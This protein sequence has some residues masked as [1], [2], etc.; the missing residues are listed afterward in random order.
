MKVGT[1][2]VWSALVV[3][4]FACDALISP[5]GQPATKVIFDSDM[6]TDIDDVGALSCLHALADAGEC[7]ILATVSCTRGN[8][9]VG[10]IQVVNAFYGRPDIPVG[11][12]KEI[13]VLGAAVDA[14]VKVD[15]GAPLGD[16]PYGAHHKYRKLL[17]DYPGLHSYA[18]SDEAPDAN[19]VYRRVLSA[20]P[21]SSVV[22]CSV[23]F[24]TNLRRLLETKPD[25]H[26]PL[27]GRSLVAK[28]VKL[29]VAMA[30]R[31]PGGREYNAGGDA[32]SSRIAIG[33]WPTPVVVADFEYGFDCFSGRAVVD[34]GR[35][36]PVFDIYSGALP[37]VDEI[38]RDPAR[39]LRMSFGEAGRA[40]WD[41]TAVLVAVRGTG[42]YFNVSRGTFRMVGDDGDNE[43]SPGEDGPHLRITEK[44]A[45]AEVGRVIDELMLRR[46]LLGRRP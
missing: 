11:C 19:E 38:R 22:I 45:K 12:A 10:A 3:A 29:W 4:L 6:L 32:A 37:P 24:L 28:K 33:N 40:S 1:K 14:R 23:G 27:D 18:D 17:A 31:Y 41:Q 44:L 35:A 34:S 21:D 13:G 36:G 26:S 15:P 5:A 42:P 16:R 8:A 25:A 7:E 2:E 20:Q 43:W 39:Y 46:P 9:S 30:F